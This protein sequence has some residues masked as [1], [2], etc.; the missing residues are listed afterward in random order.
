[1]AA[2][3][4]LWMRAPACAA[5]V[6]D[7]NIVVPLHTRDRFADLVAGEVGDP[8]RTTAAVNCVTA[9]GRAEVDDPVTRAPAAG[10]SR[11]LPAREVGASYTGSF[12]DPEG[13]AWEITWL[14]QVSAVN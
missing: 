8:S 13:N 9:E 14:D 2:A 4:A 5:V 11:W 12:A 1:M 3:A 6:L 7:D 10:G